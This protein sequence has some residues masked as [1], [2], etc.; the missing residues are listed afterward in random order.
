M[1]S[2]KIPPTVPLHSHFRLGET[3]RD[4]KL[5]EKTGRLLEYARSELKD[6]HPKDIL[7]TTRVVDNAAE[8]LNFVHRG[9]VTV[10]QRPIYEELVVEHAA[11]AERLADWDVAALRAQFDRTQDGDHFAFDALLSNGLVTPDPD[12][13]GRY[14]PAGGM[15]AFAHGRGTVH[16]TDERPTIDRFGDPR[17]VPPPKTEFE[18][19]S[20]A[21]VELRACVVTPRRQA[22]D[23]AREIAGNDR[24]LAAA[25]HTRAEV[26]A[27]LQRLERAQYRPRNN[28]YTGWEA[29][30]DLL[31][32]DVH[33]WVHQIT[34]RDQDGVPSQ[35]GPL[36]EVKTLD[37]LL[38]LSRQCP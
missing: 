17:H 5:L 9:G 34:A 22:V 28:D 31:L 11:Q 7:F 1:P 16:F 2:P 13:P 12:R 21:F 15:E 19:V 29:S 18:N 8:L 10:Q 6:L 32:H 35:F 3:R 24:D 20:G 30:L 27:A 4:G 38:A 23:L 25:G 26:D 36:L 37:D 14:L 33:V